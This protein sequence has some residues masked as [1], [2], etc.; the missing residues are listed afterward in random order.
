MIGLLQALL[1]K[2]EST[3]SDKLQPTWAPTHTH[4]H[5]HTHILPEW[6][7]SLEPDF[8]ETVADPT[9]TCK[10]HS[11]VPGYTSPSVLE[12]IECA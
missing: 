12:G 7:V 5:T 1:P 2:S 9:Y 4:V 11:L 3:A 6:G 8:P 10:F